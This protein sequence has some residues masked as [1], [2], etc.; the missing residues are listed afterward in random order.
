MNVDIAKLVNGA[1]VSPS[2]ETTVEREDWRK[3]Q[4]ERWL[5]SLEKQAG[6]RA[7]KDE[8][9]L[10]PACKAFLHAKKG[11]PICGLYLHGEVGTGKT[12]QLI[13]LIKSMLRNHANELDPDPMG[14]G[15]DTYDDRN[16][17][18]FMYVTEQLLLESLRPSDKQVDLESFRGV[19]WLMI[20]EVGRSKSTEWSA[21]QLYSI[22]DH[23]YREMMP[24]VFA[25]NLN[26]KQLAESHN[27]NYD[28]RAIRRMFVMCGGVPAQR[29]G[30]LNHHRL[31]VN[32]SRLGL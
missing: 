5:V 21:E 4:Y 13:Q 7:L 25:S 28:D 29:G 31:D 17:P 1:T 2:T 24:T 20:D 8:F 32:Y 26:I 6:L 22:L 18:S 12:S 19:K 27:A 10:H 3:S 30:Y 14:W 16:A 11:N 15:F 9:K 23:R